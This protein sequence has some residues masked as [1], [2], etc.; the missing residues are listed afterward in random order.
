M[1][2]QNIAIIAVVAFVLAVAVGYALF[3][4]TITINGTA[5]AKGT[6]DVQL[7]SAS[8]ETEK[9]STGA[10]A[11]ISGDKNTL[12]IEAPDLQYPGAYVEYVVTVKNVGTIYA[13]LL[14]VNE[15][16][17]NVAAPVKVTYTDLPEA[18]H[19]LA[20]G[21]EDTFKIKVEWLADDAKDEET[22]DGAVEN[23]SVDV[24]VKYDITFNYEQ[25][26]V[27]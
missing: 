6:F 16:G 8:V 14:S 5:T 7:L 24:D 26:Q 17:K 18:D 27:K 12:T 23:N 22:G 3:R 15:T 1:K 25:I 13:E 21:A 11:T 10:K 19:D 9:G 20:P 4:E 2:K